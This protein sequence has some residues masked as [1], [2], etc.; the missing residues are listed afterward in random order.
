MDAWNLWQVMARESK[1]AAR[2][3]EGG[4]CPRSAVSRYYYAAYQSATALLLYRGLTP[5]AERE[6]WSHDETPILV[7]MDL[8]TIIARR[9]LRRDIA[10]RLRQ[11]YQ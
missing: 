8:S 5:P 10:L 3:A 11:L 1:R 6:A 4:D 9:D 7:A 2:L